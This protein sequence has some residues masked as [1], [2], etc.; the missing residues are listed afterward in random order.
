MYTADSTT[1]PAVGTWHL[2]LVRQGGT[3]TLYVNG[4]AESTNTTLPASGALNITTGSLRIGRLTSATDPEY[5]A[6]SI[7][8]LAIY[9][10]ALTAA[11]V[12]EHYVAR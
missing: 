5:F 9:N 1:R 4:V 8:E 2:V 11:Q 6:G 12:W 10:G 3:L 7:D